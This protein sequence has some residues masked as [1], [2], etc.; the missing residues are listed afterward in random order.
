MIRIA[1]IGFSD[2]MI[3]L[4][5]HDKR[6]DLKY[7]ITS[8]NRL[9]KNTKEY[10]ITDNISLFEVTSKQEIINA[11]SEINCELVLMYKFGLIIPKE[12]VDAT[13]LFNIHLGDMRTNRGAHSLRWTILLGEKLTKM[14]L[15]RVDG[16]DEGLV[17]DEIDINVSEEDDVISLDDKMSHRLC[18]LLDSL[19]K[20][21]IDNDNRKYIIVKNGT[22]RSKLTEDDYRINLEEDDYKDVLH[23]INCVKDFGGAIIKISDELY[24]AVNVWIGNNEK[25]CHYGNVIKRTLVSGEEMYIAYEEYVAR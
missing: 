20:H 15:Y 11:F 24:R 19:Y 9:S 5:F 25:A 2:K 6:F 18:D 4:L 10:V 3:E 12:I 21:R 23:K 1:Y 16:I 14:T 22:Y 8:P 13:K 17:I 7:V